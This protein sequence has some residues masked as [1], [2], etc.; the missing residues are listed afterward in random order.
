MTNN[1]YA[2][3][4]WITALATLGLVATGIIAAWISISTFKKTTRPYVCATINPG[5]AGHKSN[6]W[7]VL[8]RNY[9]KTAAYNITFKV[10]PELALTDDDDDDVLRDMTLGL[11]QDPFYLAP[12]ASIRLLWTMSQFEEVTKGEKKLLDQK[13]M[14]ERTTITFSYSDSPHRRRARY[15]DRSLI[16]YEGIGPTPLAQPGVELGANREPRGAHFYN[17]L[18]DIAQQL[19]HLNRLVQ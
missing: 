6:A 13:G 8:I 2:D 15:Q 7:D 5:I 1:W 3:P 14:P 9:G 10:H 11:S 4:G 12:G 18:R 16:R 19:A 17:I